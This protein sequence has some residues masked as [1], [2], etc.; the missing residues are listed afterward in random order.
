MARIVL[1][2]AAL[3]GVAFLLG[4]GLGP[5]LIVFWAALVVVAG[6]LLARA[7]IA[8]RRRP[9][10]GDPYWRGYVSFTGS[11]LSDRHR[12]PDLR[13][14]GR[15]AGWGRKDLGSGRCEFT[16]AGIRWKGGGWTT[17]QS[18]IGGTFQLPWSDVQAGKAFA[19]PGRFPGLGGGLELTVSDGVTL[20]GEFVGSVTGVARAIESGLRSRRS[21]P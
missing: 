15:A 5:E 19:L 20:S 12:F 8:G 13:P 16:Q 2:L 7:R 1:F 6:I 14:R 18:R 10:T 4:P 9:Q 21:L 17:P 11:S 3:A